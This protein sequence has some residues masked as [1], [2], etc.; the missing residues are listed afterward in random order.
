MLLIDL[1]GQAH[2]NICVALFCA[3]VTFLSGIETATK[4]EVVIKCTVTNYDIACLG[5][6]CFSSISST[7]L[8]PGYVLL[9]AV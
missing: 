4:Y 6:L 5:C 1:L 9:D 7:L 2:V 8:F 3:L